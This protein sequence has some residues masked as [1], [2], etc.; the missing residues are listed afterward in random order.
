MIPVVGCRDTLTVS[1]SSGVNS[2]M[3]II[4]T[5]TP[6]SRDGLVLFGIFLLVRLFHLCC[7]CSVTGVPV[8]E[9]LVD[10]VCLVTLPCLHRSCLKLHIF[11]ETLCLHFCFYPL[12]SVTYCQVVSSIRVP[13]LRYLIQ[14]PFGHILQTFV[15]WRFVL[16]DCILVVQSKCGLQVFRIPEYLSV[17]T[18][19]FVIFGSVSHR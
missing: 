4:C 15:A 8:K 10:H 5:D 13:I 17:H 19:Q 11:V 7:L 2:I 9:N 16:L 6:E 12:I 18:F 3:L 14:E 1:N